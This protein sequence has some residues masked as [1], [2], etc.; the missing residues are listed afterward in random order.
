MEQV[1]TGAM[2]AGRHRENHACFSIV[3][4]KRPGLRVQAG[5]PEKL[6]GGGGG[7]DIMQNNNRC[8]LPGKT[9]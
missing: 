6:P 4:E 8:S 9:V 1:I 2:A 7:G 3:E 5:A